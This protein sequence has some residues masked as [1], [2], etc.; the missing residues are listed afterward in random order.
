MFFADLRKQFEVP[1]YMQHV[2]A[3][4]QVQMRCHP[5][6]GKPSP[7]V[8]WMVNDRRVDSD[9]DKNLMVSGDGHLIIVAAKV[10]DTANYTCVAENVAGTRYSQPATVTVYGKRN[11]QLR[12]RE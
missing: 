12:E 1:P 10:S 9:A 6:K 5:P 8:H 7:T 4:S 2:S 11:S 3:G